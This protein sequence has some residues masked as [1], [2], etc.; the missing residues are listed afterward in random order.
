MTA[1]VPL[2]A[3]GDPHAR[4]AGVK[5]FWCLKIRRAMSDWEQEHH[6]AGW[7]RLCKPC[8][9]RRLK[10]PYNAL[11]PMRKVPTGD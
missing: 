11:L 8:A 5:C 9:T 7:Q 10:N 1:L 3:E 6:H 4:P 2:P